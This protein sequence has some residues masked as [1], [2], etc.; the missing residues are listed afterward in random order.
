LS[1]SPA[2]VDKSLSLWKFFLLMLHLKAIL[3]SH[4]PDPSLYL[5]RFNFRILLL[6]TTR[7]VFGVVSIG[8]V[9]K[10]VFFSGGG[11]SGAAVVRGLV[12]SAF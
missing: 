1:A 2:L 6:L 7:F 9:K 4:I 5:R 11:R 10:T 3:S 8:I 12:V